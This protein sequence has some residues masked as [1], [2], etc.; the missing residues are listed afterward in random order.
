ML[1]DSLKEDLKNPWLRG[2]LAIIA[3]T[4]TVNVAF[5]TYAYTFPPNLVVQD[6]Y[7][8]GKEYFHDQ[9][10]RLKALPTAWRLQFML[11]NTLKTSTPEV[12]RL[13]VMDHEGKPVQSGHV[14]VSAYH[15]SDASQDFKLELKHVYIGTFAAPINFPIPGKWDLIAGIDAGEK[16]FDTATRIFVEK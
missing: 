10:I 2:I 12:C 5:I 14:V 4:V 9:N 15:A 13:Y 11:P 8:R 1:S 3:T 6:Y 7:E 16:H